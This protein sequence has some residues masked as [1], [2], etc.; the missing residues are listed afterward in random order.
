[1]PPVVVSPYSAEWP[2]QFTAVRNVLLAAFAPGSV[3]IEHIGSTSVPGLAAKPIIDVLLGARTLAAIESKKEALGDLGFAYVPKYEAEIPM[4]R[5]FVKSSATAPRVHLHAV[6]SDSR[7]WAEHMAF[8]GLLRTDAA[9]RDGYQALKL[10]LAEEFADDKA[11]YTDAKGPFIQTAIARV[12]DQPLA[13]RD[14]AELPAV[15]D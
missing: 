15:A 11:A 1:M 4:R 13:S 14:G 12:L 2:A 9:L 3:E 6:E 5:Y 7:L 8:R 10:R